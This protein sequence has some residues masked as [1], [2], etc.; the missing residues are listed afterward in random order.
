MMPTDR[1]TLALGFS[2]LHEQQQG[3]PALVD[4]WAEH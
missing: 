4:A 3:H 1:K 2:G